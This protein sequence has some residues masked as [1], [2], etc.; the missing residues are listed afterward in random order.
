LQIC[1]YINGP[2]TRRYKYPIH[3][4]AV[5]ARTGALVAER[6]FEER[7]CGCPMMKSGSDSDRIEAHVLFE[8]IVGRL[9]W[10]V[11]T[12]RLEEVEEPTVNPTLAPTP[13]GS[14]E[15]GLKTPLL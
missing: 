4:R 1:D 3:V 11:G 2:S 5:E 15:G 14:P 13:A 7:P 10:L 8:S 12:T 9:A 6:D